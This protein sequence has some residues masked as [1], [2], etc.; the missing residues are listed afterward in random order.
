[1]HIQEPPHAPDLTQ[2]GIVVRPRALPPDLPDPTEHLGGPAE[3]LLL[4]GLQ[5]LD[6]ERAYVVT[7]GIPEHIP[8]TMIDQSR[9]LASL[10]QVGQRIDLAHALSLHASAHHLLQSLTGPQT[11]Q[12]PPL[13]LRLE[14]RFGEI[15]LD[16][17]RLEPTALHRAFAAALE[18]APAIAEHHQQWAGLSQRIRAG[19]RAETPETPSLLETWFSAIHTP[20]F[21]LARLFQEALG[22]DPLDAQAS[23]R[24]LLAELAATPSPDESHL[25]AESRLAGAI[26]TLIATANELEATLELAPRPDSPDVS[27]L[28]QAFLKILQ[29]VQTDQ[30]ALLRGVQA[31][32][33]LDQKY[34]AQFAEQMQQQLRHHQQRLHLLGQS[35]HMRLQVLIGQSLQ[36][37]S[38]R[39][40][41]LQLARPELSTPA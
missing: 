39:Q 3:E 12:E 25:I 33:Q 16:L 2:L 5:L 1:M 23:V 9:L 15:E 17:A 8:L 29:Q 14:G 36:E 19:F 21:E 26:T 41:L 32:R 31:K 20:P 28:L 24:H 35:G 13:K 27:A 11:A 4:S 18:H 38:A 40:S 34:L 37:V 7:A 10:Q 6:F 30:A 22:F